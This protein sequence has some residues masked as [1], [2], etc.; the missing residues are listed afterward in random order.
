[1]IDVTGCI[2]IDARSA[3]PR[4]PRQLAVVA[5]LARADAFSLRVIDDTGDP[6]LPPIVERYGARLLNVSP[7]PLG[8]RLNDAITRI[9][10][11]VLIFPGIGN[12]T[13]AEAL[14]RLAIE[15]AT[16]TFDVALLNP[17]QRSSWQRLLERVRRRPRPRSEGM[18]L[19]RGWF[20]RIGGCDPALDA[21]AL[22]E[23]LERL[24]ACG[25]R[26]KPVEP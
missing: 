4:L 26:V 13:S 5:P 8:H 25:A 3:G 15:I 7:A 11:E 18:C 9:S 2:L 16:G 17:L 24:C 23:L 6:R 20:E 10:G 21:G 14:S 1:M 22:G 19:S 12:T